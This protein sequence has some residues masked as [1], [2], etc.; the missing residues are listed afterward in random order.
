MGH[1]DDLQPLDAFVL[2]HL[3]DVDA[4]EA[5]YE[6]RGVHGWALREDVERLTG[7]ALPERLPKLH[8]RAL[9]DRADVRAP[10]VPA[11]AYAYRVT[12]RAIALLARRADRE[13]HL[14]LPP[15]PHDLDNG[16][17]RVYV[18]P[19]PLAALYA[20][21]RAMLLPLPLHFGEKG[22]RTLR[23]L[24]DQENRENRRRTGRSWIDRPKLDFGSPE[25]W[26]PKDWEG[27]FDEE[28]ELGVPPDAYPPWLRRLLN[29]PEDWMSP[30]DEDEHRPPWVQ[31]RYRPEQPESWRPEQ[32]G[33]Y[34]AFWT[35]DL[36]WLVRSGYALRSSIQH[37]AGRK[38]LV[39]WRVT[40]DGLAARP[41]EWKELGP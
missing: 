20:L 22:W 30:E 41:L 27:G 21:R 1:S 33:T 28:K 14:Y 37:P 19:R 16:V 3:A 34:A 9:L 11:P 40:A 31:K 32:P 7:R 15:A 17:R 12:E 23:E 36:D 38:S 18:P 5:G 24:E 13:P 2:C 8:E 29:D 10:S 35:E 4:G 26:K 6:Y 25:E 39:T